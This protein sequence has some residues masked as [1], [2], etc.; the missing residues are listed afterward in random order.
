MPGKRIPLRP[1]LVVVV[2][3]LLTA[4]SGAAFAL[5]QDEPEPGYAIS[6]DAPPSPGISEDAPGRTAW[7]TNASGQTYGSLA[8]AL[9]P[10]DEPDLIQALTTDGKTG[11]IKRVELKAVDG[12]SV[13]N[14]DDA[15]AW[16]KAAEARAATGE[17]ITIPVYTQDGTTVI[18][19]FQLG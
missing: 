12:S 8:R 17:K 10:S 14:P 19:L 15:I 3:G 7:P 1:W 4:G 9:S 16:T 6:A 11:Y 18:G 13:Q 2:A 5:A